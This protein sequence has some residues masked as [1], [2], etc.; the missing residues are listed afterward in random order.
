MVDPS[1]CMRK[2]VTIP[3]ACRERF[4]PLEH[5]ALASWRRAGISFAGISDLVP[6]YRI[7]NPRPQRVMA[8]ATVS[9]AGWAVTPTGTQELRPGSLFIGPV[10]LP[11]GWGVDAGTW[12]IVWWYM[13]PV[14]RWRAWNGTATIAASCPQAGLLAELVDDLL[15]RLGD[16]DELPMLASN[17]ALRHLD[18]LA[19]TPAAGP[20]DDAER[21]A[22][23]WREVSRHPQEDW[24]LPRLA[25][26]LSISV[27]TVQRLARS[28]LGQ[29]PHRALVGLRLAQARELLRSTTYPLATI[30]ELAGYAD[31]FTFSAA[32]RRWAG[33]PPSAMRTKR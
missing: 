23:L 25:E 21:F 14:A 22:E 13:Q 18:A 9:G 16:D 5:P 24:S 26:R 11:V 20:A 8:I 6:G 31:P 17:L 3:S 15:D 2:S 4:A 12:R 10:G 27:S 1:F 7:A 28:Q 32:F 33:V 30:A 19:A 29:A